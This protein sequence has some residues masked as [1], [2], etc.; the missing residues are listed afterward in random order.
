M[1]N[2]IC[3]LG[4]LTKDPETSM[5][6]AANVTTF[7]IAVDRKMSK[8]MK[9]QRISQGKQV[10]DFF[11]C[12][13]FKGTADLIAQYSRKGLRIAIRGIMNINQSNDKTYPTVIVQEAEFIDFA[14]H[15]DAQ[16]QPKPQKQTEISLDDDDDYPF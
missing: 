10:T 13:A 9:E 16:D 2:S 6:G 5:A 11:R 15:G 4:R 7:T 1:R 8:A 12:E 3:L 14:K